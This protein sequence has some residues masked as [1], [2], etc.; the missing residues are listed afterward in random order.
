MLGLDPEASITE[1]TGTEFSGTCISDPEL[2]T[3]G[4]TV[5]LWIR[6]G[7][8]VLH[9]VMFKNGDYVLRFVQYLSQ[10][11]KIKML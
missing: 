6:I 2:C 7:K 11:R 8:L 9:S 1:A 4:I 5:A 3:N 10:K